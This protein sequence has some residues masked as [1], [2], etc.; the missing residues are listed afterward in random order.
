MK[1]GERL[2]AVAIVAWMVF[3][4]AWQGWKRQRTAGPADQPPYLA[5]HDS[6]P[7]NAQAQAIQQVIENGWRT[8]QAAIASPT[9]AQ[10]AAYTAQLTRYFSTEPQ[11]GRRVA[12]K[13]FPFSEQGFSPL[14]QRPAHASELAIQRAIVA[15]ARAD[16]RRGGF[17]AAG[18]WPLA[19]DYK[20]LDILGRQAVVVVDIVSQC[21][22]AW[23][24]AEGTTK[25]ATSRGSTQHTF[26]LRR[27]PQGWRILS[28]RFIFV[29]GDEP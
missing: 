7:H 17:T 29:P 14:G 25:I 5:V 8:V 15:R 11:P 4:G 3:L 6:I 20:R 16:A 1:A 23:R 2:L 10:E 13:A 19:F 22:L 28:D 9:R 18:C 21:R 12:C 27:E 24:T 26:L